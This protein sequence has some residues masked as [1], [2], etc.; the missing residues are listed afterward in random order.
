MRNNADER[1]KAFS[2]NIKRCES[3]SYVEKISVVDFYQKPTFIELV[4]FYKNPTFV[5]V[6]FYQKPTFIVLVGFYIA[7]FNTDE[8]K[9]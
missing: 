5:L 9:I 6:D 7:I 2:R 3:N 4:D 1:K 8:T